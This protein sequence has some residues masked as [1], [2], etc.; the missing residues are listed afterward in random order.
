MKV[1]LAQTRRA[2]GARAQRKG[3]ECVCVC[4]CGQ[5]GRLA[6]R[7]PAPPL[8]SPSLTL[9]TALSPRHIPRTHARE[10]AP[11]PPR[12]AHS[13]LL[14]QPPRS[15]P[16]PLP[17]G[18][19]RRG[20]RAREVESPSR[21][22]AALFL[23]ALSGNERQPPA[24]RPPSHPLH[25]DTHPPKPTQAHPRPG[26]RTPCDR[27]SVGDLTLGEASVERQ[28]ANQ[29]RPRSSSFSSP[30]RA[31][32]AR[33]FFSSRFP[34]PPHPHHAHARAHQRPAREDGGLG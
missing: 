24:P 1:C 20:N 15:P 30:A 29:P 14:S 32:S 25:P 3:G 9:P 27:G 12:C 7:P 19:L 4:A 23:S 13:G 21:P 22:R 10:P 18:G 34:A 5:F 33:P 8:C 26:P 16:G 17:A 28:Q 11:S 31:P 2:G 6:A